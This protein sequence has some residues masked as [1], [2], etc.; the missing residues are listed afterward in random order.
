M[1]VVTNI[2][3]ALLGVAAIAVLIRLVKGPSLTDRV[4]ALDLGLGIAVAAIAVGAARTQDGIFLDA[5]LVTSLL[6]FVG[7]MVSAR[8]VEQR[9]GGVR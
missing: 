1:I 6:G 2:M 3:L 8:Y 5:L 7:T 4:V 9:D